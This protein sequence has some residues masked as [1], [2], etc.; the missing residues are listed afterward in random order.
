[1]PF[2]LIWLDRSQAKI[3]KRL[4]G[5][6]QQE[7]VILKSHFKKHPP[8]LLDYLE[9]EKRENKLFLDAIR[10]LTDADHIIILGPGMVKYHFRT[11]LSEHFPLINKK[12]IACEAFDHSADPQIEAYLTH[13]VSANPNLE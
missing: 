1:M 3:F 6:D 2:M 13:Y 4:K 10:E 12:V 11:Y 5:V 9:L 7:R 8:H